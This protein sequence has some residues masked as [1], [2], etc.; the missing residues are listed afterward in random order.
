M[1][2]VEPRTFRWTREEFY[3]LADQGCFDNRRVELI[4]GEIIEMPV[5]KPPHVKSVILTHQAL[6]VT[7]GPGHVVRTQSPINLGAFSDAEPDVNVVPGSP[8]DYDDH[9]TTSLLLVEVSE[10]TLSYD[11]GRKG[12]LYAAAGIQ[13]YW[14]VNLV[15]RQLEVYRKPIADANEPSG[16]RYDEKTILTA[17]E[18]IEPLAKPGA[19]VAVADLL[20]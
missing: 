8:R 3:R 2:A 10:T 7:F 13:D 16:F 20:P 12:S 9:P 5:P 14:I 18:L 11:R 1:Q 15:D 6:S 4:E 17:G 19:Q